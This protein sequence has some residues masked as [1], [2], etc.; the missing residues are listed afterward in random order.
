[1]TLFIGTSGW[2][3]KEWKPEFYPAEITQSRFLE[4]YVTQLTACEINATFYRLQSEST[5]ARWHAAAPDAFRFSIKA[6]RRIT[7]SRS[8]VPDEDARNFIAVFLKSLEPLG[9]KVG[10]ILLQYPPR[11][12]RDDGALS[13][14]LDVLPA[15]RRFAFEFRHDSWAAPEVESLIAESGATL[16]VADTTAAVPDG[17][18]PGRHAYVRLRAERYTDEQRQGWLELL[19]RESRERD[20]F[21]FSKH[22]GIPAGDEYGGVGLAQ[23]LRERLTT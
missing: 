5:F 17:L 11:R 4:H 22:E 16:C 13:A 1:M 23:W 19:Q 12:T 8:M 10:T 18:P 9:S 3:Y 20:V 21:V 15:E 7:H 2:A 14:L 6:H